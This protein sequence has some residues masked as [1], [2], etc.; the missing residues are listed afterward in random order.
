[1]Y[2]FDEVGNDF[3]GAIDAGLGAPEG[4]ETLRTRGSAATRRDLK[5]YVRPRLHVRLGIGV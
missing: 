3:D 5:L 1:M 2:L 4:H